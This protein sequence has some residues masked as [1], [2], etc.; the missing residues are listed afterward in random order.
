MSDVLEIKELILLITI[1]RAQELSIPLSMKSN[2]GRR[3]PSWL[4][5]NL[6][7]KEMDKKESYSLQG[8]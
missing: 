7:V 8:G 4:N 6:L 2:R 1:M 3:N 5:K